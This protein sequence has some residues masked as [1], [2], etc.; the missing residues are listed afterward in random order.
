M[1]KRPIS[2]LEDGQILDSPTKRSKNNSDS[3]HYYPPLPGTIPWSSS[4]ISTELPPL[5]K[6]L[7]PKVEMEVFTHRGLDRECNYELLEWVGDSHIEWLATNLITHTFHHLPPGRCSQIREQ[8]VRNVTLAEYYR[9]YHMETKT[10][11]PPDIGK[12]ELLMATKA[13]EKET[14]KIQGDIFEAYIAGILKSDPRH[15]V[16]IANSWLRSLWGRTIKDQIKQAEQHTNKRAV[17]DGVVTNDGSKQPSNKLVNPKERLASM[18]LVKGSRLNYK[19]MPK[20]GD[21]KD[22]YTRLPLFIVGVFLEGWGETDKLLGVGSAMKKSE[23]GQLAATRALENKTL[24][25]L[26]RTKKEAWLEANKRAEDSTD[27][28]SEPKS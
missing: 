7:D 9:A 18:I 8:L 25:K 23:A 16:Q 12:M 10:R 11:L 15:G 6:I 21:K 28:V 14:I 20:S 13:K 22:R 27:V 26:Y 17:T 4:D 19:D 1:S 24:M 5:P 2:S 3:Q